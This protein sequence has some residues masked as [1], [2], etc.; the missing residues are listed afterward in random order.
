MTADAERIAQ[1]K[2][3]PY[4]PDRSPLVALVEAFHPRR[5]I[6]EPRPH[7][8]RRAVV[9]KRDRRDH[10]P[11]GKEMMLDD[12]RRR[13]RLMRADGWDEGRIIDLLQRDVPAKFREAIRIAVTRPQ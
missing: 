8:A 13:A 5:I 2:A 9:E 7:E 10:G 4:D 12:I 1:W 11:S 6:L 3:A